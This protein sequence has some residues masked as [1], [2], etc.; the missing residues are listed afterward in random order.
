MRELIDR[1]EEAARF[2][3]LENLCLSP[4]CGCSS[5]VLGNAI[6]EDAQWRKLQLVVGAA[7]EIWN[8]CRPPGRRL[9]PLESG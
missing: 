7:R 8:D 3:A 2:V 9:G 1:V 5:T 4:Q 6:S